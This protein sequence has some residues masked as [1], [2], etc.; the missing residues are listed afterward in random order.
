MRSSAACFILAAISVA[1]EGTVGQA[2]A[3]AQ[4]FEDIK[5]S[6][7]PEQL[8][9]F[10]YDL[11]KGGDLHNHLGGTGLPETW[12]RLATDK[13]R[14][15]GQESYT[16]VRINDCGE[17]CGAPL[18]Y[19]T[20]RES[21]WK[22]LPRCCQDE[23][24][25][26]SRLTSEEEAA[27]LSSV[28]LDRAGE[29]RNEF[30][31][32]IWARL[33]HLLRDPNLLAELMVEN[34]KLFGAE[35][36]RYIEW[37]TSPFRRLDAE[38]DLIQPQEVHRLLEERL[39]RPDARETGVTVRFLLTVLRF[40]PDA[41]KRIQRAFAFL[42]QH[43]ARWVGLSL[44]GR[45]D[46]DRGYPLRFL[47]TFRKMRRR[48]SGIGLA[49]HGGEVDEPGRH[50]RD[51]LLLGATR[52]GH[53]VNLITDADTLLLMR[54]EHYLVETSL[55]SNHLLHYT[56][57]LDDHPFPEY[58]RLGIPVCLNT[59]DRG[60]W[61]SNMTDEYYAA[62]THF[63]LSWQEVVGLGR[64]SLEHS[65]LDGETK[66]RLLQEYEKDILDLE[67]TY[68]RVGWQQAVAPIRPPV[69]GYARR[70]LGVNPNM[71]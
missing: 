17:I 44:V 27:W 42:D 41:E 37:Q 53:G 13:S 51:T 15:G 40:A 26:M 20:I 21:A 25:A 49:I 4:L 66:A 43:R 11:P 36:V 68:Q 30:F 50:V 48:Y 69:S 7:T 35:G 18:L 64:N 24:K 5:K 60:M 45:E 31:E 29:G 34:M 10:L 63:N 2:P 22:A 39:R 8:Y 33:G 23:Y 46:N 12:F 3:F 62:V 1:S 6:A 61:D 28:R 71:K 65:F 32:V 67:K 55:V 59:D 56:A 19:H 47:E 14:N 58:L 57:N 70:H 54:G 38:G 16:R 52:I 9:A